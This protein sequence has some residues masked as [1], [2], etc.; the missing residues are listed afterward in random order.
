[1]S[2][3]EISQLPQ[4]NTVWQ[5]TID[6]QPNK[7]QTELFQQVYQEILEGN[8]Q[9]NLT[10]ITSPEDFWKSISGIHFRES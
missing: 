1:M 8:K 9:Q 5:Q 6:W 4:M 2:Q 7:T 10:R 3:M